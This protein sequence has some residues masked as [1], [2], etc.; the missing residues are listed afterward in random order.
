VIAGLHSYTLQVPHYHAH[1]RTTYPAGEAPVDYCLEVKPHFEALVSVHP[2]RFAAGAR[3]SAAEQGVTPPP[4]RGVVLFPHGGPHSAFTTGY[5]FATSYLATLGLAVVRVNFRGSTGF[6]HDAL[7][8][9]P[10]YC[11][12]VDVDDCIA[13][14]EAACDVLDAGV[15]RTGAGPAAPARSL[16]AFL[17]GGSHGGYLVTH[18]AGQFPGRFAAV[19]ARNAVISLPYTVATSDIPD[20]C[21]AEAGVAFDPRYVMSK[22]TLAR[23]WD[24]S[25]VA[26]AEKYVTPTLLAIGTGDRRV[27][28]EQSLDF[29]RLLQAKGVPAR[30]T[31]YQGAQHGLND[32]PLIHADSMV[33]AA[34]WFAQFGGVGARK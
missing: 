9:L 18:L 31:V 32:K 10:G 7:T 15:A 21:F 24:V 34:L 13:A 6:G 20:W 25:P 14:Y 22:E 17:F 12:A 33:S 23:M 26:H 27:P 28:P 1:N 5:D 19:V 16:P 4:C 30:L 2:E 11:G 3:A 29:Y 8:T